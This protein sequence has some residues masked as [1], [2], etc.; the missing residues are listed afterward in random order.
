MIIKNAIWEQRNL[1]VTSAEVEIEPNDTLASVKQQLLDLELQYQYIAVKVPSSLHEHTWLMNELNYDYVED[2]M[3]FEH[4]LHEIVRTPLQQRLYDAVTI[5]EMTDKDFKL[6][7]EE[8]EKGSFSFV[9]RN[10]YVHPFI[11]DLCIILVSEII[12]RSEQCVRYIRNAKM[13]LQTSLIS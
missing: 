3:F 11:S 12:W 9:T 2:M 4:D 1:G 13:Y 5:S 7:H 6:L 10:Y 8:I